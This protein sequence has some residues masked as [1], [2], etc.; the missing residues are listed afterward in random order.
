VS[1]PTPTG[2]DAHRSLL[3]A[4]VET[5][6]AIFGAAAASIFLLDDERQELVFEA[7]AGAG[8]GELVGR[9]FPAGGGIAGSV[10]A[11]GEP[12]V[13]DD[14]RRDPRFGREAAE[15][16]GH[17]PETLM[18]VPLVG[19]GGRPLGVL[20]VLDRRDRSRTPLEE[21]DLL[22]LFAAQAAIA[23]ELLGAARARE[24]AAAADD[25]ALL[26]DVAAV[27]ARLEGDRADAARLLLR[28]L[29][30]VAAP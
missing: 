26:A 22:G 29:R 24:R 18:A 8:A 23:V 1:G 14:V 3:Q 20:E 6:R 2:D 28:A 9:R 13:L 25:A 7:V 10:L 11:T 12:V 15:S 21:L 4:I 17:V 16:T 27:L 19:S 5:A 30:D